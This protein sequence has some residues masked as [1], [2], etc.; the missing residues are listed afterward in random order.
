MRFHSLNH[1]RLAHASFLGAAL[2]LL[3]GCTIG[4]DF[5]NPE[6]P[7]AAGWSESDERISHS[8]AD[9]IEWWKRFD[10]PVLDRL[11]KKASEQNLT[12]ELA[13]LRVM[14]SRAELG[15]A[16]GNA[17]PQL[18]QASGNLLYTRNPA[19]LPGD[20]KFTSAFVGL[21]A[22]WE[23]DLWGRFRRGITASEA[24]LLADVAGYHDALVAVTA[25][26][27]STYITIRVLEQRI[28]TA[29]R[30]IEIQ[31]ETTDISKALW[32]DGEK[33]R[34]DYE[35]ARTTLLTTQARV[36]ALEIS[37]QQS[38]HALAILLGQ[39]PQ[40]MDG[41]LRGRDTI[42]SP[43]AEIAAGVPADLLRQRPDIRQAEFQAAA[44]SEQIGIALTDL[45][46]RLSL[47]GSI[48]WSA[49]DAPGGDLGKLFNTTAFG[50]SIGPTA[51][52]NVLNY[53]RIRN[54]V[55]VQDA[56]FQQ[57]LT[58]YQQTVLSAAGEVEDAIVG[59]GKSHIRANLLKESVEAAQTS[60]DLAVLKYKAGEA[61]FQRVLDS[62]R[63]LDQQQDQ[64]IQ[65]EGDIALNAVS[66]YKALGGGWA[67]NGRPAFITD[68]SRD[69]MTK[70][71]RW[72]RL[73]DPDRPRQKSSAIPV[74]SNR[75]RR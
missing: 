46:P 64:F 71:T 26:V 62:T 11:V 7:V 18:Q 9:T 61:D 72:G 36:P 3:S 1:T 16:I 51:T 52:W 37:L 65:A 47:L 34:L 73:L 25:E 63:A 75:V 70:R 17:Y 12:I 49:S 8:P 38:H 5:E 4:P 15:I 41:L 54:N 40:K 30:N 66:L 24:N 56:A 32:D 31:Q 68:R 6:A 23:L 42:P 22:S 14:Q 35:Q 39:P 43:S 50:G 58:N 45:Y 20:T 10:D 59:F 57:A 69:Q 74:R 33:S 2:A 55:R 19:L 29:Q 27:A 21:D 48:G 28:A 44:Q 67:K 13:G 60:L 53:G